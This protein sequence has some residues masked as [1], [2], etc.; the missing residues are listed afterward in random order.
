MTAA[1]RRYLDDCE[2]LRTG[3]MA[4][5]MPD[6]PSYP[7]SRDGREPAPYAAIGRE[8]EG[9]RISAGFEALLGSYSE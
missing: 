5:D 1:V 6:R 7:A 3:S 8:S 4:Q 9:A 2:P